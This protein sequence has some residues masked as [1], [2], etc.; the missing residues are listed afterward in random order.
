MNSVISHSDRILSVGGN[1]GTN[2][3][4]FCTPMTDMSTL[5][6]RRRIIGP[7]RFARYTTGRYHVCGKADAI[8]A[9]V[10]MNYSRVSIGNGWIYREIT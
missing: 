2:R 10:P 5:A 6:V 7:G 3:D 1:T 9:I 4:L 8:P